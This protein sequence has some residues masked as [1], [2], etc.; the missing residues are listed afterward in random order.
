MRKQERE[1]RTKCKTNADHSLKW[2]DFGGGRGNS[3]CFT[4]FTQKLHEGNKTWTDPT[5]L[6]HYKLCND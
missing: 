6:F 4:V 5:I 2:L 3:I 1:K